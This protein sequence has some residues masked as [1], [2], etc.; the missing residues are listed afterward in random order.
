MYLMLSN[1]PIC[2]KH[3]MKHPTFLAFQVNLCIKIWQC[4]HLIIRFSAFIVGSPCP[5]LSHLRIL[6][7]EHGTKSD[8]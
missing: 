3:K 5:A 7:T 4:L 8:V 1:L 2:Y 6:L